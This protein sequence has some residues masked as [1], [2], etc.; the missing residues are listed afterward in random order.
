MALAMLIDRMTHAIE[1]ILMEKRNL[2]ASM[3]TGLD[4]E[5]FTRYKT[6][7]LFIIILHLVI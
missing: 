3:S 6:N 1:N 2:L 7:M 5:L 4:E